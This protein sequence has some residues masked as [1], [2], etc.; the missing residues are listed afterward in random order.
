MT[1]ALIKITRQINRKKINDFKEHKIKLSAKQIT[2]KG[3]VGWDTNIPVISYA[4]RCED[5]FPSP[6]IIM[7]RRNAI[8]ATM[9]KYKCPRCNA[10]EVSSSRAF[11][12]H[13]LDTLQLCTGC[14]KSCAVKEWQCDC[15]TKWHKCN[16][17][18][19]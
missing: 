18:M 15:N 12:H 1:N 5:R 2:V 11:Q 17:H 7:Q 3:K 6:E 8:D 13:D 16:V 14:G 19:Y 9:V 4:N 10:P